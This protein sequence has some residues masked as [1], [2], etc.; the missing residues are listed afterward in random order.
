MSSIDFQNGFIC[1]M[2]TK[3]LVR[4][5]NLY[6]PTCWNDE[7]VFDY[8]YIDFKRGLENFSLGM[9]NESII[10]H[11]TEQLRVAGVE[12]VSYGVYKVYCNIADKMNGITV[13]N[14]KST[15]L[16]TTSGSLLPVFSVHFYVSGV[17]TYIRKAYVY[18]KAML[19]D[20]ALLSA[21]DGPNVGFWTSPETLI[22]ESTMIP[23][24]TY[25]TAETV[26]ISY[27]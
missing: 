7:G 18:E 13:V 4:S 19:S 15:L 21:I 20:F 27:T 17:A 3:G 22:S 8:F 25:T 2:A 10:V 12:Y 26:S 16:T 23:L 6:N 11:D 9:F 24:V 1:G 5:G 14:K